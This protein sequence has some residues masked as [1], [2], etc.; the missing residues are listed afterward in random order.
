MRDGWKMA[1]GR[2]DTRRFNEVTEFLLNQHYEARWW[3]DACLQYFRSVSGRTL[4]TGYAA[5]AHDLAWYQSTAGSCP[6]N[7]SKP[8]CPAVYTGTPSPTITP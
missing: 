1:Q 2:I 6:S 4:P 7:A 8:R 5:P 3:R